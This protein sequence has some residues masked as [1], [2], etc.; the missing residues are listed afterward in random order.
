MKTV[1]VYESKTGHTKQYAQWI[2]EEL[3]ADLFEARTAAPDLL[4][5][6]DII[7]FGGRLYAT[8]IDGIHLI[9]KNDAK[10]QGKHIIVW[11]TGANP[12]RP[13]E[14]NPVWEKNLS[15]EQLS[16]IKTFYLR[17]GFDYSKLGTKDKLLMQM[18]K[19]QIEHTKHRTQDQED[20]LK[21]YEVP[22]NFVNRDNIQ[23]L[24]AYVR[25]LEAK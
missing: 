4:Q 8:G 14:M 6:Y 22:V 1:V 13:E 18:M 11:A 16:R 3:K 7:I 19:S 9:T 15:S 12:G 23:P 10:L 25:S 2:A 5:E 20:L 17:G 21:A 24:L